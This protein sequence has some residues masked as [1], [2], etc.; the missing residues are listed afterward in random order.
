[1]N[2]WK[3]PICEKEDIALA[4]DV[5]FEGEKFEVELCEKCWEHI[6]KCPSEIR[7]LYYTWKE[8]T[9][10]EDKPGWECN[11]IRRMRGEY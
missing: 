8:N 10:P 7:K 11:L 1:M 3:C 5:I 2:K 4:G 9:E 6:E